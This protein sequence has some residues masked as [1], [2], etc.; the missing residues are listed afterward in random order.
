[1]TNRLK[2]QLAWLAAHGENVFTVYKHNQNGKVLIKCDKHVSE[3][4]AIQE[5]ISILSNAPVGSTVEETMVERN[6]HG[7]EVGD[8]LVNHWQQKADQTWERI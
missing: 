1:M 8:N 5:N 7:E 6:H 4:S 2:E 3:F